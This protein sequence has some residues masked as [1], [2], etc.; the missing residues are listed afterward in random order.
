MSPEGRRWVRD[1]LYSLREKGYLYAIEEFEQP[2]FH[3]MVYRSYPHYV[4]RLSRKTPPKTAKSPRT[5]GLR[6]TRTAPDTRLDQ[7]Q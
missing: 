5:G 3:V 1:V 2:A 7:A 6:H 4:K